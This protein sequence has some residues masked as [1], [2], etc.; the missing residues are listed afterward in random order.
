MSY[1]SWSARAFLL[2]ISVAALESGISTPALAQAVQV[3]DPIT[4]LA[5]KTEE[6]AIDALAPVSTVRQEQIEQLMPNRTSDIFWGVPGVSFQQRPDEPATS[7]NIRG[8]QDFG[9]VNVVVDGARQN[10]Q[11]SG[12]NAN[13]AFYLDPEMI[14]DADVVRGP[15]AYIF[16]SGAIGG[17]VSFRTKDADDILKAGQR[18]SVIA[19]GEIGSNKD[20]YLTSFMGATRLTPNVD[21][22]GGITYRDQGD[23]KAG[24]GGTMPV[25]ALFGPDQTVTNSAFD[26]K[27]G[28][29]K[30]S[31]RPADGHELKLSGMTY[32]SDYTAGQPNNGDS[33][34]GSNATTSTLTAKWRYKRPDDR[35]FD[36]DSN[37]YWKATTN[38]QTKVCCSNSIFTGNLGSTREFGINTTGFDVNNTSRFDFGPV[39]NA[40]TYGGDAF[41]DKVSVTDPTGTGAL[42]TPKGDRNVSGSFLQWKANF[43]TWLELIGAARYD[44][45][46]L[47]GGGFSSEGD[48]ISPKGTVGVTPIKG[49]TF[50]ATYA[51]G[52]RAPAVTEALISGLHPFPANF[53]FLPN[54]ELKPEVG[55]T[56]ELGINLKYD[57][58]FAQ[59]D[60]IRGKFNVYRNNVEDYIDLAFIP[61]VGGPPPC[62]VPPFCFQYQNITNAKIEGV[63]F[64]TSYDTGAWFIGLSGSRIRG[65]DQ[66]TNEPLLSIPADQ[67]A[68]TLGVRFYDRKITASVRWAAVAAKDIEDVPVGAIPTDSYNLVSLY[69]GYQP[70]EDVTAGISVDNLLNEYYFDYLDAQ[71]SR[72]PSR[73]L[74][75]KGSL[76]VRFGS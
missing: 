71:T 75:V 44:T 40:L 47:N 33:V 39:A 51:E 60:K 5:T 19:H 21:I 23:F 35:L 66:T 76:K 37:L 26:V 59:N 29:A 4:V 7:I 57:S 20:Q 52:Y 16:G 50:Y 70:T 17:V 34:F 73:G 46:E 24:S 28:L 8:L 69:L 41:F 1:L 62:V 65:R 22:V 45:Y 11:R 67:I 64:E 49:F 53:T 27:T 68:S 10:F 6:K 18:W 61:Y 14:A 63:E 72:V 13:G 55:K 31:M 56:T 15:V 3:L 32:S 36:F 58:V 43:S 2:A 12:H 48:R 54:P 25:G 74:S 38:E 9:R 42:F 30:L